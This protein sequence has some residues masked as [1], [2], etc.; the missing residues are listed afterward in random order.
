MEITAEIIF[1]ILLAAFVH[2]VIY[3]FVSKKRKSIYGKHVLV[4]GGSS[5]IGLNMAIRCAR[6]G[7]HVTVVARSVPLLE[8]TVKELERNRKHPDQ[9][10]NY[11]SLDI[12]MSY[13][14]VAKCFAELEEAVGPIYM[15]V[16]CAGLAICGVFEE[17][18]VEDTKK[19]MDVNYYGTYYCT[20]WVLPKMKAAKEGI[21]VITASQAALIGLYGYGPYAATKFALRGMAETIA[22]ETKHLG[23]SVT[24]A[25]PCDTN[26]PG[27]ETEEK[28]K[29]TET[30]II[31]ASG[32]LARPEDVGNKII[33]DALS[34]SFFSVLGMESWIVTVLCCGMA[35]WGTPLQKFLQVVLMGPLRFVSF[36]IQWNF[37]RIIK[38][39][40]K[41]KT[42]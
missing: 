10:F 14:E 23:I 3:S 17:V 28:T 7:A 22:M 8:K 18:S 32:G 35:P 27:F 41:E 11:K 29:P 16:N 38:S 6:E 20:R 24:L 1:Y 2:L 33:D 40:V 39:C 36:F 5:G 15:L 4:T 21:V 26:T 30:K 9:K 37:T 19:Q 42:N 34:G 25:L 31:S 13:E 12:S